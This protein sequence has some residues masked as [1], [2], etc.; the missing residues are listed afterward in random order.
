MS[1]NSS[2]HTLA[3][4]AL[5]IALA[6]AVGVTWNRVLLIDAWH[7]APTQH[8]TAV[9]VAAQPSQAAQP[10]TPVPMPVALAQVKEL[11]DSGQ[12]VLV[13]ARSTASFAKEHIKG[14]VSLPLEEAA[15]QKSPQLSKVAKDALVIAYCNGFSC[16]DSMEL[17]KLLIKAGYSQVYVFE[18]GL[19]EWRDAGYPTEGRR[20]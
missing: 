18:G 11:H 16:H 5:L 19:P 17:G 14:A 10:L 12:A 20:S 6:V 3:E 7:G 4:I 13:D 1:K 8:A 9:A 15:R 2:A